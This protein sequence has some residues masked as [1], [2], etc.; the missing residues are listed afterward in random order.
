[1]TEIYSAGPR[2][3][4]VRFVMILSLL[5][6]IAGLWFG[7]ELFQSY[8]LRPADGGRLAPIGMRIGW[9]VGLGGAGL[10]F[11]LGMWVYGRNY[12]R[13]IRFDAAGKRLHLRTLG[14]FG[15][16][17]AIVPLDRLKQANFKHGRLDNPVGVSVNAPWISLR[18][19]GRGI[20]YII[21]GQGRIHDPALFARL[22]RV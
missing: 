8:G 13:S 20:P 18:V 22:I 10:I 12:V 3:G 17:A 5:C 7:F 4:A 1:M 21:D 14:M 6:A 19:E 16:G 2:V 15:D 9:L 11:A